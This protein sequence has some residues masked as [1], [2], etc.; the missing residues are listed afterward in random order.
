MAQSQAQRT[1]AK[2]LTQKRAVKKAAA[3]VKEA[4]QKAEEAARNLEVT[5]ASEWKGKRNV[6]GTKLKLPSGNVALV[7]Q[8][9]LTT[10]VAEGMVPNALLPVV[11]EFVGPENSEGKRVSQADVQKIMDDPKQLA[12]IIRLTDAVVQQAVVK[13]S[14]EPVPVWTQEDVEAGDCDEEQLGEVANEKRDPDLL[15]IDETDMVDR[16]FIFQWV[17]GGTRDMERFR[18]QSA[19]LVPGLE[20]VEAVEPATE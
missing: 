1:K 13:P 6:V 11:Q 2:Q 15:Y 5:D 3:K 7:K 8:V 9:D 20:D 14:I 19:A 16:Q 10:F 18:E 12:D 17:V 4:R